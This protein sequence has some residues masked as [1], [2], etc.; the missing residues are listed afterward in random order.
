MF[1]AFAHKM[2]N[3]HATLVVVVVELAGINCYT[4]SFINYNL[5]WND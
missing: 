3:V 4:F 2:H 5:C 1:D